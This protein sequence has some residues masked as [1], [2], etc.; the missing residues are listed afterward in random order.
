MNILESLRN[1]ELKIQWAQWNRE[2]RSNGPF[3][4]KNIP[5]HVSCIRNNIALEIICTTHG[6]V[7]QLFSRL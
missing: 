5:N 7:A 1:P 4:E 6:T 2:H 3:G